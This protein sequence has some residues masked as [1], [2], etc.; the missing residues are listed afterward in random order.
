MPNKVTKAVIRPEMA[1]IPR[2]LCLLILSMTI[3]WLQAATLS[4]ATIIFSHNY[5]EISSHAICN[6]STFHSW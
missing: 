3:V 2:V 6:R 5:H 4:M 1:G